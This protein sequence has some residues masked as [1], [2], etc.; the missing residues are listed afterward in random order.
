METAAGHRH[1]DSFAVTFEDGLG[2]RVSQVDP[3]NGAEVQS[4]VL[5]SAFAA[6][7]SFEFSLRE[8]VER[9]AAF[10][11]PQ[12]MRVVEVERIA[13][14]TDELRVVYEATAG[15]RLSDLLRGAQARQVPVGINAALCVVRQLVPALAA[16]QEQ[17]ADI[18]HGALAPERLLITPDARLVVA[19]HVLGGALEQLR[20][21]RERYWSELRIALP[22]ATT[23]RL[24]QRADVLQLGLIALSLILGRIVRLEE[25][26][27]RIPDV[28]AS[29]TAISPQGGFE[30]LP[31][32]VRGWLARALQIG[33]ERPFATAAEAR[34]AFDAVLGNGELLASPSALSAFLTR[35]QAASAAD[36][37]ARAARV[38]PA[39]A[40]AAA[41]APPLQLVAAQTAQVRG[42]GADVLALAAPVAFRR[43][44][45]GKATVT[46]RRTSSSDAADQGASR[47][48]EADWTA[49]LDRDGG[50][51]QWW[52]NWR[53]VSAFVVLAGIVGA[54]GSLGA[55]R[56]LL[57]MVD[58]GHGTLELS[59][60][61]AG[62]EVFIDGESRGTTPLAVSLP[63]GAHE[64]ELRAGKARRA[65]GV[66]MAKDEKI[67][68]QVKLGK[69]TGVRPRA[70][71]K[72][73]G[74]GA[75]TPSG[76]AAGAAPAA[77][78]TA[79]ASAVQAESVARP[80]GVRQVGGLDG[81]SGQSALPPPM[82]MS[83]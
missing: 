24:D 35:Y 43:G 50:S 76:T 49:G 45:T 64:I 80:E 21:S 9:L 7:P 27:S 1:A 67:K 5:R 51:R 78:A 68:Q 14:T 73:G 59:S 57:Q 71:T 34:D 15:T 65:F 29:T 32:G 61:P 60:I 36:Q 31:A 52:W 3:P 77:P 54:S 53:L 18:A 75:K 37:S 20:Y 19:D 4:L 55:A 81:L 66:I 42:D 47:A 10:Q 12:F 23:P 13:G 79:A 22:A 82:G 38:G 83:R 17:G 74:A 40:Q 58:T 69:S 16:L 48:T 28:L 6:V 72:T 26:P 11:H 46:A 44:G 8:R 30:P 62:A 33:P 41:A 56:Q 70:A 63:P 39:A 25:F 2:Q